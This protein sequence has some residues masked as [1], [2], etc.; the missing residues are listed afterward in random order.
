[1]KPDIDKPEDQFLSNPI[2]SSRIRRGLKISQ[3]VS[4]SDVDE[5]IAITTSTPPMLSIAV[6]GNY[7]FR[8][9]HRIII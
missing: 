2:E 9:T 8:S 4:T 6:P 1:M 7:R 3:S 5:I